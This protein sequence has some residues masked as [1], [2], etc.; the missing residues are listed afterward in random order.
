MHAVI[1][2][3]ARTQRDAFRP[4]IQFVLMFVLMLPPFVQMARASTDLSGG[5]SR[6]AFQVTQ[7]MLDA[8]ENEILELGREKESYQ[9]TLAAV[10]KLQAEQE[11]EYAKLEEELKSKELRLRSS[12]A[13][14]EAQQSRTTVQ[15]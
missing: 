13:D 10:L 6:S 1:L 9:I 7:T 2:L 4:D 11:E 14:V 12:I 5:L 15:F 8:V 3:P